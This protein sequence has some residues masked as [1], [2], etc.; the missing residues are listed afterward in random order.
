MV[1]GTIRA[2]V[3]RQGLVHGVEHV[4]INRV[5]VA[6]VKEIVID[7]LKLNSVNHPSVSD[8][9]LHFLGIGVGTRV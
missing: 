9:K 4:L 3:G 1:N 5:D 8:L 7:V 6:K 2:V